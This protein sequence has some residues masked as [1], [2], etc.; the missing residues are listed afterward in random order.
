M[1]E[2]EQPVRNM[3]TEVLMRNGYRIVS[4]GNGEE[5]QQDLESPGAIMYLPKPFRIQQ[6]LS[7]VRELLDGQQN[8]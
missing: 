6:L 1:V 3:I 8:A 4:A 5:S 2:D 7:T